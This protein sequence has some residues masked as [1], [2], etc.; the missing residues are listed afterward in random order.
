MFFNLQ[1]W[2][3]A[4]FFFQKTNSWC[5]GEL[6][7]LF[8]IN[9]F[10]FFSLLIHF[11]VFFHKICFIFF[12][13][14]EFPNFS[15]LFSYFLVLLSAALMPPLMDILLIVGGNAGGRPDVDGQAVDDQEAQQL[16]SPANN[17]TVDGEN[18]IHASIP[19]NSTDLSSKFTCVFVYYSF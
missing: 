11:F 6:E 13:G 10:H 16:D 7:N 4:F 1:K 2:R 14:Y 12:N 5:Q 19:L 17:T 18:S 15:S 3:L 9:I 8:I